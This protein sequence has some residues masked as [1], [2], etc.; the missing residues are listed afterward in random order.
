MT[1]KRVTIDRL[2]MTNFKRFFGSHAIELAPIHESGKPLILVG[3]NNGTGKTSIH[4][5]IN[6]ALY[7]SD[8]LPGVTTR[9]S[10]IKA[11]SDRL[12]RRALDEGKRDYGVILELSAWDGMVERHFRIKRNWHVNFDTRLVSD[13][14]LEI[15]EDG[16]P[17]EWLYDEGQTALPDF[18]RSLLPPR[19]AP[20]FFFDGERIQEFA[21]DMQ[22]SRGMVDAIEDI[23]NITIYKQLRKD[24][25]SYVI[26]HV[27]KTEIHKEKTDDFYKLQED[28]ERIEKELDEKADRVLD[29]RREL[30]EHEARQKLIND[31]LR[32]TGG[33]QATRREILITE[34]ER[35]E[36]E[37][38][39]AKRDVEKA[40]EP[41]PILL[42]GQLCNELESTLNEEFLTPMP[43]SLAL[44]ELRRKIIEIEERVFVAPKPSPAASLIL[45]QEQ[46]E[47][48]MRLHNDIA[49]EVLNLKLQASAQ[50][51]LHDIG[52]TE[53][54]A[55]LH[56]L[57]EATQRGKDL[58]EVVNRRERLSAQLRDIR[59]KLEATSESPASDK[60][61]SEKEILDHNAGKLQQELKSVLAEIQRLEADKAKRNR[62]IEDRQRDRKATSEAKKVVRLAQEARKV[63]DE[64]IRKLAPEKLNL[65]RDNFKLMYWK[66]RKADD[67]VHEVTIDHDTWHVVLKDSKGRPLEKRV[68][69]AGMKEMYALSLLWGLARASGKELPI[70]I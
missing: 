13:W 42:S 66:L 18:I 26:D 17:L 40:F 70:L 24:L 50:P 7:E 21:D 59:T 56:R 61:L 57:N 19:I 62:Q 10:Y 51:R 23:L 28:L 53:R 46:A 69:S 1:W 67:P 64:F 15:F 8:D 14:N 65:L 25:K 30:E 5:A 3:G 48:Y 35:I 33:I 20:F 16:R 27:E 12:N 22:E 34:R 60:L 55:I 31:E 49:S 63:L 37:L 36:R 68:F 11:V 29:I 45:S 52:D 44:E 32:R 39:D 9:P 38:N 43:T 6:Y 4:E 41:L 54:Q 47:F 58:L 2:E